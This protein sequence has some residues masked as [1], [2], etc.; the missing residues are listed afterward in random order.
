M[1][2]FRVMLPWKCRNPGFGRKSRAFSGWGLT[3]GKICA[4]FLLDKAVTKTRVPGKIPREGAVW[5]KASVTLPEMIPLP[6]RP[7]EIPGR[8]RPLTRQ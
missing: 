7:V 6:S 1:P 2:G 5:C 4:K 8:V 3:L